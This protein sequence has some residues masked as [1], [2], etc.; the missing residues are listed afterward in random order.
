VSAKNLLINSGDAEFCAKV[1]RKNS[2]SPA[3]E[4]GRKPYRLAAI[5]ALTM[6]GGTPNIAAE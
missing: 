4:V 2:F 6:I 3:M 1:V 5:R